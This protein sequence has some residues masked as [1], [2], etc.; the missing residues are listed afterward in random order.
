MI[1][2]AGQLDNPPENSANEIRAYSKEIPAS[3]DMNNLSSNPFSKI[4]NSEHH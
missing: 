4:F 1:F 2:L 3:L